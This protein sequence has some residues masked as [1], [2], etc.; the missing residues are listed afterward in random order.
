MITIV[1][2]NWIFFMVRLS[3]LRFMKVVLY[4][5]DFLMNFNAMHIIF[6]LQHHFL[7]YCFPKLINIIEILL[8]SVN[9]SEIIAAFSIKFTILP[10]LSKN[11]QKTAEKQIKSALLTPLTIKNLFFASIFQLI[12]LANSAK[13]L[14]S[15]IHCLKVFKSN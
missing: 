10:K 5:I 12:S 4:F 2:F 7:I 3:F 15:N 9:S 6:N 11:Q 1:H 14:H 13:S 8:H